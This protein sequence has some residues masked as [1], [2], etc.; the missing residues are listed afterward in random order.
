MN[1]SRYKRI[2]ATNFYQEVVGQELVL[3]QNEAV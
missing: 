3:Y 2:I 1:E